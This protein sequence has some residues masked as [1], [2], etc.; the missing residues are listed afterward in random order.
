[1]ST[2]YRSEDDAEE[3]TP[4]KK[5][6]FHDP[7]TDNVPLD[8][9]K[10]EA[11]ER[12]NSDLDAKPE[13]L[14]E[15]DQ[16]DEHCIICLHPVVDRTVLINCAHDR[17]CFACIKQWSGK[18]SFPC[19]LSIVT[20]SLVIA[21]NRGAVLYA[22][23]P[24][25]RTSFTGFG[26]S[27]TIRSTFFLRFGQ[28]LRLMSSPSLLLRIVQDTT[29][30]EEAE[31]DEFDR[32]VEMR[33][34]VYRYGLFAKHVASNK[35]TRFRPNP[36]P[37]QIS[38]SQ[39]LQ[40]RCQMFVRRELR[41][42]P[43]LDIE[44]LTNFIL[45]LAKAIDIRTE[46]AI[47]LISEF[48]D[49]GG[50]RS[51]A[52]G[53]I[54][55]HFVHELYSYLR[56]PFRDL[57]AYDAVVQYDIPTD[58][59]IPSPIPPPARQ[60]NSFSPGPSRRQLS[61][62]GYFQ[63]KTRPETSDPLE[64]SPRDQDTDS[65]HDWVEPPPTH[66]KGKGKDPQ[67]ALSHR[68]EWGDDMNRGRRKR[69]GGQPNQRSH[70]VERDSRPNH[71]T[72]PRRAKGHNNA[73]RLA[74]PRGGRQPHDA[75]GSPLQSSEDARDPEDQVSQQD[76]MVG[77]PKIPHRHSA[78]LKKAD[79]RDRRQRKPAGW[80]SFFADDVGRQRSPLTL[81]PSAHSSSTSR[82][83]PSPLRSSSLAS[84]YR[85]SKF[86]DSCGPDLARP[87]TTSTSN[88]SENN[89]T[90][91]S[92]L[93]RIH[94]R[95]HKLIGP[96]VRDNPDT[97]KSTI[98]NASRQLQI[99]AAPLARHRS[100]R[101]ASVDAIRMHLQDSARRPQVMPT[102]SGCGMSRSSEA[103]LADPEAMLS[104]NEHTGVNSKGEYS[105]SAS[106][107]GVS[108]SIPDQSTSSALDSRSFD[109]SFPSR[110]DATTSDNTT[111]V[112]YSIRGA[113]AR[114]KPQ[115]AHRSAADST[116][117]ASS[118]PHETQQSN[119]VRSRLRSSLE[120]T[121]SVGMISNSDAEASHL[122]QKST[123]GP[124]QS[125]I[126][127]SPVSESQIAAIHEE[128]RLRLMARGRTMPSATSREEPSTSTPQGS[129][130]AGP[131]HQEKKAD[132][133]N[134]PAGAD[135]PTALET[136]RRLRLQARLRAR[137]RE[138]ASMMGAA[139]SADALP[140]GPPSGRP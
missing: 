75:L 4:S 77:S 111:A 86:S 26:P 135:S 15:T 33:R 49:M 62:P 91:Q 60:S 98:G 84:Q 109:D 46:A 139:S 90:R 108:H 132:D 69:D 13:N 127:E 94:P 54:A 40:S 137:K 67:R 29:T 102:A 112:S 134:M 114:P 31:Q 18:L 14:A 126:S 71:W 140:R 22:T 19:C 99:P 106:L 81:S 103:G 30:A 95:T 20:S 48:L 45:S 104:R 8:V 133:L 1:M 2:R 129:N 110:H 44:F 66:S 12:R 87:L 124:S 73:T 41:V 82:S 6:K 61:P 16:D 34:W 17:M 119:Q 93:E 47:K 118:G 9:L 38:S 5:T 65:E 92:S 36:T 138:I 68:C 131:S 50:R 80:D 52:G 117:R 37:Q 116:Q 89:C 136:E 121:N 24:S 58:Q 97:F 53:T 11:R 51:P 88:S 21:N 57:P 32:A 72:N 28:V 122:A 113:A 100:S 27:T 125:E 120:A 55:E 96:G 3:D 23:R 42:W 130:V 56:S 7:D 83:L 43:N 59:E 25:V 101:V 123:H 78:N 105:I 85:C 35:H 70:D 128:E 74:H 63:T 115:S 10:A 79:D 76:D 39:E 107:H 64:A